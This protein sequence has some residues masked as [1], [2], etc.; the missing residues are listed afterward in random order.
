MSR[1][2]HTIHRQKD[3]GIK[4]DAERHRV[5]EKRKELHAGLN[6]FINDRGGWLVSI[7]GDPVMRFE[8][9]PG[10]SLPETLSDLGYTVLEAGT[11]Q[12]VLSV[13]HTERLSQTSSG[14]VYPLP[15]ESSA[16]PAR[17]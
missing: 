2:P 5:L 11:T 12:R 8:A 13:G 10:S 6:R 7:A 4:L 3:H 9:L 14:A 17:A 15:E 16:S 1:K